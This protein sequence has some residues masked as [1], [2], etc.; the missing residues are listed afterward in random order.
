MPE[1][2]PKITN[3]ILPGRVSDPRKE[4]TSLAWTK[5]ATANTKARLRACFRDGEKIRISSFSTGR[6]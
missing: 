2:T 1:A 4:T 6:S 3:V 5:S